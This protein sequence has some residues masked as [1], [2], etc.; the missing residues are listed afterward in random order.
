MSQERSVLVSRRAVQVQRRQGITT[1]PR[2]RMPHKH[3]PI[4]GSAAVRENVN[5]IVSGN[6]ARCREE[7]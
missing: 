2:F 4:S 5:E 7:E 6:T 3:A 1:T